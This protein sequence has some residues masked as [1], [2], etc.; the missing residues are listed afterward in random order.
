MVPDRLLME[1]GGVAGLAWRFRPDLQE[2]QHFSQV[3]GFPECCQDRVASG[4]VR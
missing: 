1:S 2:I 4:N 3:V